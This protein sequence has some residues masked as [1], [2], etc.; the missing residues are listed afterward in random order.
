MT[1]I[2]VDFA[3]T[4]WSCGSISD[5]MFRLSYYDI[6]DEIRQFLSK[7][8]EGRKIAVVA[9]NK[10]I[11]NFLG[12]LPF[13][14][15]TTTLT[16]NRDDAS[17]GHLEHLLPAAIESL[18]HLETLTLRKIEN[19]MVYRTIAYKNIHHLSLLSVSSYN[20][21]IY[22]KELRISRKRTLR[23]FTYFPDS[24]DMESSRDVGILRVL[25]DMPELTRFST[26]CNLVG[27]T[28]KVFIDLISRRKLRSLR[29]LGTG[30]EEV[31]AAIVNSSIENLSVCDDGSVT[32][33]GSGEK[34]RRILDA[35]SCYLKNVSWEVDNYQPIIDAL[36]ENTSLVNFLR[37]Y[38]AG[39]LEEELISLLKRN[40]LL[41]TS[42]GPDKYASAPSRLQRQVKLLFIHSYCSIALASLPRE[43]LHLIISFL[44]EV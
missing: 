17:Y 43:L 16:L 25:C 14:R 30:S 26:S 2:R 1:Y 40:Q 15:Y 11:T 18:P 27:E 36:K 12:D 5:P 19:D 10:L 22:A 39:T 32:C 34:L 29:L 8:W 38:R 4:K 37:P 42:W 20:V 41:H 24:E 28:S 23:S 6:T 31:F 44:L 33:C 21:F 13:L 35:P 3:K 7:E 9:Y